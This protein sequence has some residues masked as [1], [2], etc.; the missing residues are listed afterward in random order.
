M[1]TFFSTPHYQGTTLRFA[2]HSASEVW[3]CPRFSVVTQSLIDDTSCFSESGSWRV[4]DFEDLDF[5]DV[6]AILIR[7]KHAPQLPG[8]VSVRRAEVSLIPD[9]KWSWNRSISN[10]NG[11]IAATEARTTFG[12]TTDARCCISGFNANLRAAALWGF[13]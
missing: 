13:F 5:S 3:Q 9:H 7:E 12:I 8:V 6:K 10:T 4:A 11:T 1:T 2:R